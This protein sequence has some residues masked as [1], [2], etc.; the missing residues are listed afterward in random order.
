MRYLVAILIL[1]FCTIGFSQETYSNYKEQYVTGIESHCEVAEYLFRD[2]NNDQYDEFIIIGKKG[3]VKTY[4]SQSEKGDYKENSDSMTLAFP[5]QSLLSLS[6]FDTNDTDLYLICLTPEGL[7]AYPTK[8]DG[9]FALDGILINRRMKFTFRIDKPV[10]AKFFQDINK[11]GRMDVIVPVMNYCEIWINKSKESSQDKDK[12]PEFSRIG[13]FPIEMQHGRE[14]DLQNS[15]GKLSE[16]FSIPNLTLKDIN[17]DGN[18][19]LIV[20]HNPNYD[21]Y[22]LKDD[23]IIP[24]QPTVSLDLSLFQDTTPK[25]EGIQFGETLSINDKPRLLESDLNHDKIP[26]YFSSKEIVGFSRHK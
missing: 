1:G 2:L 14:T 12:I 26:Y 22:L 10:F 8:Q 6:S 23:G 18:L 4:S 21:Y 9:S 13:I 24:E 3:Q 25:T 17:N 5:N 20:S 7:V 15:Q 11:D 16:N 19:D